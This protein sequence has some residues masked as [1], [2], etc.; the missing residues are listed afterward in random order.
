MVRN[1]FSSLIY[2]IIGLAV[3]GLISQLF[4]NTAN[5]FMNIVVM[6]GFGLAIFA[7]VYFLFFKK[8]ATSSDMRKYKQAVKQS[9]SKYKQQTKSPTSSTKRPHALQ[10]KK[11]Q[12]K[13]ASHLRV[14]D[15]NKQKRKD[16]ATF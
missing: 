5:F 3:I 2:I 16:R 15:G 9:K 6:V 12:T 4:T 14:I 1:K 7:V 11:K 10:M 13:R 8:R